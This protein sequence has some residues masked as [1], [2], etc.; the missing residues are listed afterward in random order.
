MIYNATNSIIYTTKS[1]SL[2]FLW[3]T[4]FINLNSLYARFACVTFWNGRLSFL[5][6]TFCCVTVSRA[7][8]K[9]PQLKWHQHKQHTEQTTGHAATTIEAMQKYKWKHCKFKKKIM[10]LVPPH[11][12]SPKKARR[13]RKKKKQQ[14]P[15]YQTSPWAPPPFGFKLTY[16]SGTQNSVSPKRYCVNPGLILSI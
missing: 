5:M 10:Q 8:L 1:P 4:S 15:T 13:K 3:F 16:R 2:T 7:A 11:R 6:A 12:D 9:R 14:C